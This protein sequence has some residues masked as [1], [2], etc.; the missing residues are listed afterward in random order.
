M[1][2]YHPTTAAE[3]FLPTLRDPTMGLV[4]TMVELDQLMRRR[5][6][7]LRTDAPLPAV[8]FADLRVVWVTPDDITTTKERTPGGKT[9]R[10]VSIPIGKSDS[11]PRVVELQTFSNEMT[12]NPMT[13]VLWST[14]EEIIKAV[15]AE[16]YTVLVESDPEHANDWLTQFEGINLRHEQGKPVTTLVLCLDSLDIL[17]GTKGKEAGP[18]LAVMTRTALSI[19]LA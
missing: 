18:P 11:H 6:D 14:A 5:P 2:N 17:W 13:A 8:P 1:S 4:A 16:L 3:I 12:L 7:M 9:T 10:T 15:S 19:G